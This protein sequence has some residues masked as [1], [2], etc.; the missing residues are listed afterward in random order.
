MKKLRASCLCGG[1]RLEV[2]PEQIVMIN[3]CHC[4]WCRKVSGSAFGTMVQVR[5]EGLWWLAGKELV[6]GYE[7][8]VGIFRSFCSVCGSRVPATDS[9]DI[10][11]VPAGLF[12]DSIG[13][14]PEVD[15]WVDQR[16]DWYEAPEDIPQCQGRGSPEF[17]AGLLGGS[18]DTYRQIQ[19][20]TPFRPL[21]TRRS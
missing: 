9:A 17:W 5:K 2:D 21:P 1:I 7:S 16:A 3:N 12:D 8:S 19:E 14:K 11:G 20:Q 6:A 18:V 15:M 13:R 4:R 10:S